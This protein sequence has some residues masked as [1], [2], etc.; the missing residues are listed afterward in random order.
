M[1]LNMVMFKVT[2]CDIGKMNINMTDKIEKRRQPL[3]YRTMAMTTTIMSMVRA[4]AA[5]TAAWKLRR[6]ELCRE[7]QRITSK[8]A[9]HTRRCSSTTTQTI[10][11]AVVTSPTL[12]ARWCSILSMC[13]SVKS[14]LRNATTFGI[15]PYLFNAKEFDEETGLYYYGARYYDPR[16]SLWLSIDPKEEKYSNV[17]T[18]CYVISNPLKYTDPTGMEIDMTK[19]RLADEQLKLST[20]QSVIKDL[21]SQTGLQ[22]SLD[23]DNKLQYAKNDEG[24]PIVNKITNTKGKEIDAGSKTARNILIKMIDNKTEIEVSYH[25]KRTV[26]S[27]TQIGLSFEQISNMVKGAV[28]VDGNTLGFGMTFLHELHHTTIG[29]DYHDSTELFG[30]GPVVDNMNIIRNELNKQGFNYGER[31]NYKAIHTKEGNIIPF[32]ESALTSLKYNSSMG[33]KAHYIKTK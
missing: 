10:W 23:K 26:T 22:L 24:K 15:T 5:M 27:G 32:N 1:L 9:T 30:T 16:L 11:V 31:L 13:L 21:A 29:G 33:K 14:L 3:Q 18:Y 20:T 17:S 19:V 25:A 8:R 7:L 28:G 12:T 4:S 2:I 6:H